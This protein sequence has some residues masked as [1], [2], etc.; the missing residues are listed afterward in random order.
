M[1]VRSIA[2][3]RLWASSASSS[4][5]PVAFRSCFLSNRLTL[6]E[7]VDPD[8]DAEETDPEIEET[9]SYQL[10]TCR[11]SGTYRQP[12]HPILPLLRPSCP[13]S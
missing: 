5:S 9:P 3:R 7:D 13:Q 11:S 6:S 1:A 2:R 8:D 10:K 4:E 12:Y